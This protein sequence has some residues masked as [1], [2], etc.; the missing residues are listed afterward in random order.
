[1][2]IESKYKKL[3]AELSALKSDYASLESKHLVLVDKYEAMLEI[4]KAL[5]FRLDKLIL[6]N[7][8]LRHLKFGTSSERWIASEL[9]D[10]AELTQAADDALPDD[11][12]ESTENYTSE[13]DTETTEPPATDPAANK[14]Q[15]K[16]SSVVTVK[17]HIR[18]VGAG[19][20]RLPDTL[21]RV[22]VVYDVP[23]SEREC[24]CCHGALHA[25]GSLISEQLD[26]VPR[27]IQILRHIRHKYACRH[28][29]QQGTS[30]HI[31]TAAMPRQPI[32]GSIASPAT[33]AAVIVSKY[34]DGMPLYRQEASLK[35][36]AAVDISRA[37][38]GS[39]CI[40]GAE[41][42]KPLVAALRHFSLQQP[43]IQGD[44]TSVQ[45]LKEKGRTPQS[46]SCMWVYRTGQFSTQHHA[47]IFEYQPSR[48]AIHLQAWLGDYGGTLMTDGY[49]GWR[50]LKTAT[51]LGCHSHAR[52]KF[53]DAVNQSPKKTGRAAHA[54]TLYQQLYAI[55]EQ[56]KDVSP[57]ERYQIRQAQAVPV[58]T[59]FKAWLDEVHLEATPESGLGV[60]VSYALN[61][62]QYLVRYCENG[63]WPIDNNTTERDIRPFTIGRRN[64]LFSDTAAGAEA[65]ATLYSIM[66]T[67]RANN[68]NPYR[69]LVQV[70]KELPQ[71][72]EGSDL[73]D[74]L[75]FN[76]VLADD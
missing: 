32:P 8:K 57:E 50:T 41:L 5:A 53:V 12:R 75:P 48:Q 44:E 52:R 43:V 40:R 17:S 68:V 58:L 51:H 73:T 11:Q 27:Q 13:P 71:R 16:P 67:C 14:D 7:R 1:M 62:W 60:A 56:C 35:R 9:F 63:L 4:K 70:L 24:P 45:V 3:E 49:S 2:D 30:G 31:V 42:L 36:E 28:C 61:Q 72:P 54:L 59:D 10:E 25:I 76:I 29:D 21:P 23:P 64:W 19:R 55:E 65:S 15:G 46:K 22:D 74:L 47:V 6:Q 26:V 33:L 34:A 18:R 69:Y 38:L 66:L 39:W 37:T 20:K